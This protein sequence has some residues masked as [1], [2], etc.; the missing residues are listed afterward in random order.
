[1]ISA[2]RVQQSHHRVVPVSRR[3]C[4][5]VRRRLHQQGK[6]ERS[7]QQ[8]AVE[9]LVGP[10]TY[11]NRPC[12]PPSGARPARHGGLCQQREILR[13]P[14]FFENHFDLVVAD[15][16]DLVGAAGDECDGPGLA[17]EEPHRVI[18]ERLDASAILPVLRR[19][20]S[21]NKPITHPRRRRDRPRWPVTFT[22]VAEGFPHR[23]HRA[24]ALIAAV[25]L[26]AATLTTVVAVAGPPPQAAAFSR[27]G[28]PIEQLDV[29]SASMGRNIRVEFQHGG[30][31]SVLLLDGLRAR[32]DLNGWDINTAAFDWFYQ[33][34]VSVVMPV[35]GQSSFYSD[36]YRP[37]KGDAG[38]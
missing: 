38:T 36:W 14:T 31:H 4:G 22:P 37:A 32:D 18:D 11:P 2:A 6:V 23:A 25:V 26:L 15:V 33:S 1:M 10:R 19:L 8:M 34:G 20:W 21:D 35:G 29:P 24:G 17:A 3:L 9:N 27:D 30:P 12:G 28:L 16:H 13:P 7:G 5:G